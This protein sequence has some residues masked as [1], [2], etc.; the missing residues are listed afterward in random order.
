[1]AELTDII[2]EEKKVF[3]KLHAK[4]LVDSQVREAGEVVEVAEVIAE[5]FGEIVPVKKGDK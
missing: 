3:V 2:T 1:M 5:S 4:C